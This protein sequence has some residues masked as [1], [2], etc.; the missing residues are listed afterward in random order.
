M[1]Q[2]LNKTGVVERPEEVISLHRGAARLFEIKRLA[3][4]FDAFSDEIEPESPR[5]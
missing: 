4:R 5:N 3:L 1:A 2:V